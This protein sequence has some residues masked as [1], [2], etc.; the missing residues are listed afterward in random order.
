MSTSFTNGATTLCINDIQHDG[1]QH[2]H[3][4]SFVFYCNAERPYDKCHY[5][6]CR[7][8]ESHL[9]CYAECPYAMCIILIVLLLCVI[10]LIV[11]LLCVI[12]L[13]VLM[14]CH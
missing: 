11:L 5:T 6:E 12:I 2:N 9:H 10:I 7:N 13:I 14:L 4:Q 1:N 3:L 8:A